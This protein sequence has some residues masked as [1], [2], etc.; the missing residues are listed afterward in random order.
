M[1]QI[2][3]F[4][5][6]AGLTAA[7]LLGPS[8]PAVYAQAAPT[9][10]TAAVPSDEGFETD[11]RVPEYL[12]VLAEARPEAAPAMARLIRVTLFGGTLPPSVK[13]AMGAKIAEVCKT[14]YAA[15]H[16]N[17]IAKGLPPLPSEEPSLRLAVQFADILTRDVNGIT[18][19][20]F[21]RLRGQFNDAQIVE[22]TMTT[23]FFNYFTR[24]T[25]GLRL[26]P[27]P[28]LAAT[29]PKLPKP[30]EN[31]FSQARVTL[32][33]DSEIVATAD[34]AA[35]GAN[36]PLG[37]GIPNS[38]RAMARVPD[39]SNAWWAYGQASRNGDEVSRTIQLQVSLAVSTLNGC[40]YC[41][42]HQVVGLKRQGVETAKL[43]ALQKGDGPLTPE[44]KAAVEFAR[45]L[46]KTPGSITDA[47]WTALSASFPGNK[48]MSILL[49]TCTFAYMN[50]FTDNLHLPSEDEAIK[51]Y[52]DVYGDGSYKGLYSRN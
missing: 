32:L 38:R 13:A 21:N 18:D 24:L 16:L 33:T 50:R 22:L 29:K 39:L 6:A 44:E 46:T 36:T 7:T 30:T 37:V 27:E 25:A 51:V 11:G 26:K 40:R 3:P 10:V 14:P 43:L 45:K 8:V 19:D 47:D 2:L 5:A 1:K 41:I 42:V 52:Q 48:A 20:I 49:Q 34:L 15:A 28:W 23:C 35:T 31:P 9:A 4:V 17:R 12:R